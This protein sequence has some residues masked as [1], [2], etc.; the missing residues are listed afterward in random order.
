MTLR[1]YNIYLSILYW[2]VYW[3]IKAKLNFD[4]FDIFRAINWIIF[5]FGIKS[6]PMSFFVMKARWPYYSLRKTLKKIKIYTRRGARAHCKYYSCRKS[7][8]NW[9][10]F[11]MILIIITILNTFSMLSQHAFDLISLKCCFHLPA[12]SLLINFI[13]TE[14]VN[15]INICIFGCSRFYFAIERR[16]RRWVYIC[17]PDVVNIPS[18]MDNCFLKQ[19]MIIKTWRKTKSEIWTKC[20]CV[21]VCARLSLTVQNCLLCKLNILNTINL[22]QIFSMKIFQSH[23]K[24]N[25]KF[26][27]WHTKQKKHTHHY[28]LWLCFP[29]A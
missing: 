3:T 24:K 16:Q 20:E 29:P 8:Q 27:P 11:P 13:D 15:W 28:L 14:K 17:T 22:V 6:F 18:E 5:S 9:F 21:Y 7:I 4:Y 23:L 10:K 2:F 12:P 19:Q 25:R 26:R 1:I